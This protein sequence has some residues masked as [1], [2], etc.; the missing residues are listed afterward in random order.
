MV[1]KVSGRYV[2]EHSQRQEHLE[3]S[4]M[5]MTRLSWAMLRAGRGMEKEGPSAAFGRPK[6]QSSQNGWII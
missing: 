1:G 6:V 2:G 4:R 5:D 3:E